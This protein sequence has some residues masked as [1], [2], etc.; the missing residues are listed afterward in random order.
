MFSH[1]ELAKLS[2]KVKA[3]E[4]LCGT[5]RFITIDG[6]AGSGKTTLAQ[7]LAAELENCQIV[8][9]D[10]L[11]DGWNQDLINELPVRIIEFILVPLSHG[12][13]GKY[14]RY[15]WAT[16]QFDSF[17]DV[18]VSKY[19]ILE[20]VGSGHPLVSKRA[21]L[22][23]WIEADPEILLDRLVSRDG[24]LLKPELI[25][26]Q[27]HEAQYFAVKNIRAIAQVHLR[28]DSNFHHTEQQG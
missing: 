24:E 11:Y 22:S 23:I 5:T 17:V 9:M 28:G 1:S 20:G 14:S 27:K 10:D 12:Q 7:E 2:Q 3:S 19:L 21:A 8:H 25:K 15:N 4:N 13:V 26:W 18:P 16:E 6:P